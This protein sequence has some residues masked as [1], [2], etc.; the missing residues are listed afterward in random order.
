MVFQAGGAVLGQSCGVIME[1]GL[2]KSEQRINGQAGCPA[3]LTGPGAMG[4]Q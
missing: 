3:G 2:T 1:W 4:C